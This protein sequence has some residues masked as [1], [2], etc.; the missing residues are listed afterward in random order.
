MFSLFGFKVK[1]DLSWFILA[2]LIT[3]SLAK[4]VFPNYFKGFTNTTYWVMGAAGAIGLFA[5]IIFHEFFHSYI[6]KIYGIPMKGITLFIFGGVSEMEDEPKSPRIEFYMAIAGPLSSLLLSGIFYLLM[7]F[8]KFAGLPKSSGAVL[9]Y[10]CVINIVLAGFNLVP[11]FPLDGGR[12]LRS[13]LWG[14]K[15]NLKWATRI[16]SSFGSIFGIL[17]IILGVLNF[18]SGNFIGGLWYFLIGM[19]IQNA[20]K[21]SYRQLVIRRALAGEHVERFMKAQPI[22]VGPNLTLTELV[23]EFYYKYH[24][25]MYPVVEDG[26]V[27]GCITSEEIKKVPHNLWDKYKVKDL[28]QPCTKDNSVYLHMDAIKALALMSSKGNSRLMVLD[29]DRLAGVITL[30]DLLKFLAIKID[31]E[32]ENEPDL[33]KGVI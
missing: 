21:M 11:A 31:L 2:I 14:V 20:S 1:V 17:L 13:V 9:A 6:A 29:G 23:S 4:G 16:A 19:F 22:T 32:S 24:F 12:V 30:K 8:N 5:S 33:P 10:L 15:R 28:L 18:I 27:M 25:K 7:I 3:W 26:R